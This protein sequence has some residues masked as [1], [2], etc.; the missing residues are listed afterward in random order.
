MTCRS[1]ILCGLTLVL[2]CWGSGCSS[3]SQIAS[4]WTDQKLSIDGNTS[5]WTAAQMNIDDKGTSVGVFNDKDCLYLGLITTNT[6]LQNL[7][8]R[9]GL[10]LWF[11]PKA[12]E[13]KI[14]GIH[15]P[16]R[17][18]QFGRPSR[19]GEGGDEQA[20][21][22]RPGGDADNLEICGPGEDDRHEMTKAEATGVDVRYRISRDTLFYEIKVP[23]ADNGTYPFAIGAKPGA[24]IGVGVEAGYSQRPM[25][26][27]GESSGWGGR[28]GARNGS[29][30]FGGRG[31]YSGH[32]GYRG[33][34]EQGEG[35][36]SARPEPYKSWMKVQLA[37]QETV[38]R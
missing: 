28:R 5:G 20:M 36:S 14:F 11:D 31:E 18:R 23:L 17:M 12:G 6:D 37:T 21:Y 29:D 30:G 4:R 27:G 3:T 19:E 24:M 35:N 32:R 1:G 8:K 38:K 16:V 15:Y 7:I 22:S 2:I 33:G 13:D 25:R 34:S 26:E 9:Q 10:T